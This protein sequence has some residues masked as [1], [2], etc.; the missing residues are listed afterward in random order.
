[1]VAWPSV[2]YPTDLTDRE[3]ALLE[4]LLP[5]AKQG[6]RPRSVNLR[7]I[8]ER[9]LLRAAQWLPVAFATPHLWPLVDRLRLRSRLAHRRRVRAH[10]Y[11]PA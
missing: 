8:R 2:P 4:P 10:P 11:H 5:P 7:L 1:M 6:G 9:P 3:W